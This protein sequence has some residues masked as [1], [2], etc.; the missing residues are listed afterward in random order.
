LQQLLVLASAIIFGFE[1]HVPYDHNLLSQFQDS[2]N[3]ETAKSPYLYPPG[4]G[5]LSY[6]LRHW[7]LFSSPATVNYA[8]PP[9]YAVTLSEDTSIRLNNI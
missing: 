1:S 4:T 5:W 6:T 9:P 3:L 8:N 7:V 2:P